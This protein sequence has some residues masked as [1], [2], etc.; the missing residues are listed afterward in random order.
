MEKYKATQ[1]QTPEAAEQA[2]PKPSVSA[3][4]A[5]Q[6]AAWSL[7]EARKTLAT[8]QG[9][10]AAGEATSSYGPQLL[11]EKVFQEVARATLLS[12][13]FANHEAFEESAAAFLER[14]RVEAAEYV[15]R[16]W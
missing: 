12:H 11:A 2:A 14:A 6:A 13:L 8:L 10:L 1:P 9:W 7:A 3:E 5:I 16:S 15:E 4:R